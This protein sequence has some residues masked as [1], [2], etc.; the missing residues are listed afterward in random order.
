[1]N[2]EDKI[3]AC[4]KCPLYVYMPFSPIPGWGNKKAKI[5][6][7]GEAPGQDEAIVEEPF[8][9]RCGKY[10]DKQ[11]LLPAGLK[12]EDLYI[13]NVVKCMCR[14]G[15]KNRKPKQTEINS[16]ANWLC[17]EINEILPKVII[18][19][20]HVP[21][22]RVWDGVEEHYKTMRELV[23]VEKYHPSGYYIL[24]SYHPSYLMQY[25][26]DKTKLALEVFKRAKELSKC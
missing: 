2:L 25:G 20:G 15:N 4:Q 22:K 16:C 14:D 26:K 17:G 5:M 23:G 21:T 7:V 10:L 1:M 12:R 13:T 19:L 24:P 11:L 9:G 3:R 18:S 8:I 6:L